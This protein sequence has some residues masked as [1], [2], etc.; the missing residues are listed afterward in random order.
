MSELSKQRLSSAEAIDNSVLGLGEHIAKKAVLVGSAAIYATIAGA[1]RVPNDTD[2][3][4]E[5]EAY[6]YL[7]AQDGWK[8]KHEPGATEGLIT[9]GFYDVAVGW[10]DQSHDDLAGRS[11]QSPGGVRIAGLSDVLA[12][13]QNRDRE[14]DQSDVTRVRRR[15]QNPSQPPLPLH[16]MPFERA[17]VQNILTERLHE[18]P[19]AETALWVAANGMMS[20]FA[21][22][23]HPQ[24]RRANQI[25]GTLELPEYGVPA[26]Y[27]N[28]FEL[29]DDM[30]TLS[31]H[32]EAVRASDTDHLLALM[33]EPYTDLV[34]GNG[35][36]AH[37]PEGENY[38]EWLSGRLL[39]AH[40]LM[41]G[42][43]EPEA[44]R[45]KQAVLATIFNES[46]RQQEGLD[47]LDVIA[48]ALVGVDLHTLSRSTSLVSSCDLAVE[49][50]MSAR[51]SRERILGKVLAEAE[52]RV[53]STEQVLAFID[54]HPDAYPKNKSPEH[55]VL[56]AYAGWLA[57][58]AMMHDPATGIY[59][60]PHDW[61][62]D[63]PDIRHQHARKLEELAERLLTADSHNRITP[64]QSY[65]IAHDHARELINTRSR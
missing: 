56:S 34:Y 61:R 3:S 38:D 16:T 40:A 49:D 64:I 52:V 24:I 8:P 50:G 33:A 17:I 65:E 4:V 1:A 54:E 48:R 46:T 18:H 59:K 58:S 13:K 10:G 51:Y 41:V 63:R 30:Q 44:D 32:L 57:R 7:R 9:N 12:W 35:R 23:G 62:F 19:G 53:S 43:E 6:H 26:T 20:V 60:H 37:H 28:G 31:Q 55:N 15:L 22:Y 25:V 45:L 11:W 39:K 27:H 36:L 21:L 47:S 5:P 2:L 29:A 42:Y 14:K